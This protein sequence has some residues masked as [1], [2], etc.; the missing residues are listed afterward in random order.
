MG[1]T[2]AAVRDEYKR[3]QRVMTFH[4]RQRDA[5][6]ERAELAAWNCGATATEAERAYYQG[7]RKG[8]V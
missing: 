8:A 5:E 6:R 2:F 7:G 3:R 1:Q 4:Y